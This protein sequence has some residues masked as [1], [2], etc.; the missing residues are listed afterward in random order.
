MDS[1]V[2]MYSSAMK[3][4]MLPQFL[5]VSSQPLHTLVEE[6]EGGKEMIITSSEISISV[7]REM[8]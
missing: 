5:P 2:Q 1:N 4:G 7:T 3:Q 6:V 8:L